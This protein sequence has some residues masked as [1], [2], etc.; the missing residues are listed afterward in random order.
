[1][2]QNWKFSQCNSHQQVFL[3]SSKLRCTASPLWTSINLNACA[4]VLTIHLSLSPPLLET[5]KV[6]MER[7][8]IVESL[9]RIANR[10]FFKFSLKKFSIFLEIYTKYDW[11]SSGGTLR[12]K[13][14]R[15]WL[16]KLLWPYEEKNIT[17]RHACSKSLKVACRL[18]EYILAHHYYKSSCQS[19][20]S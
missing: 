17:E 20:C 1:M 15:E 16:K 2:D 19:I 14:Q 18:T 7:L 5:L 11:R 12:Q 4:K 13:W 9:S 6:H 8:C 10:S 3:L